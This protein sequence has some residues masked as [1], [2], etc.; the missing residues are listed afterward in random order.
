MGYRKKYDDSILTS[1]YG[2]AAK[3]RHKSRIKE[4]ESDAKFQIKHLGIETS[5]SLT[6]A[7]GSKRGTQTISGGVP[8][9]FG[10]SRSELSFVNE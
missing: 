7:F 9:A 5:F 2:D 6:S 8:G 1:T 4:L 3:G 10:R